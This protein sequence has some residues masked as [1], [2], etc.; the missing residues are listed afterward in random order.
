MSLKDLGL[1]MALV[2][3]LF[4]CIVRRSLLKFRFVFGR[5]TFIVLQLNRSNE[6]S[7]RYVQFF[8]EAQ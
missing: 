7:Q 1:L 2:S 5:G 6:Q 8:S 3:A 4:F